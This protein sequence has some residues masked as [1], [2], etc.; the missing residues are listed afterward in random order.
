MLPAAYRWSESNGA[1][2]LRFNYR[3][4]AVVH[5][6]GQVNIQWQGRSVSGQS[7]TLKRGLKDVERWVLAQGDGLPGTNPGSR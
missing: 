5:A 7:L 6:D 1:A 3:T 4:V 2:Y